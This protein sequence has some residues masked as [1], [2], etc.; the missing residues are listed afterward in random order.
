MSAW[1][2]RAGGYN[3]RTSEG[4]T[5][6]TSRWLCYPGYLDCTVVRTSKA[7]TAAICGQLHKAHKG[8]ELKCPEVSDGNV[9]VGHGDT[10]TSYIIPCSGVKVGMLGVCAAAPGGIQF[11][12]S[13]LT[14]PFKK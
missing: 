9:G 1:R 2:Y 6:P 4:G 7:A 12:A 8:Q 10:R 14:T 3:V 5:V 11:P 13:L